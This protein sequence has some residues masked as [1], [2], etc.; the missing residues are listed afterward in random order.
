[1]DSIVQDR[2]GAAETQDAS[3]NM[4]LTGAQPLGGCK[5]GLPFLLLPPEIRV[6]ILRYLVLGEGK[7]YPQYP[8]RQWTTQYHM[9]ILQ[10]CSRLYEEG[11]AIFYGE[12]T[13]GYQCQIVRGREWRPV[14][15]CLSSNNLAM[16][17][18]IHI[19][20]YPWRL[21]LTPQ[22]LNL[23]LVYLLRT[24]CSLKTLNLRFYFSDHEDP[25]SRK[26][27]VP[28]RWRRGRARLI[29]KLCA[30]KVQQQVEV[31]VSTGNREDKLE[32]SQLIKP[33]AA[34]GGWKRKL[35]KYEVHKVPLERTRRTEK[36]DTLYEWTWLLRPAKKHQSGKALTS[37][38]Q[39]C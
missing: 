28:L 38:P 20:F 1:M 8:K 31:F 6:Q 4:H 24:G 12:N 17:R 34:T 3:T 10:T 15:S 26:H 9:H 21:W 33:F 35:Q 30:L 25:I 13:I 36:Y 32:F 37:Q 19:D 18:H 39:D 14:E 7:V 11:S 27:L 22:A 16:I 23:M 29:D 5:T 2:K